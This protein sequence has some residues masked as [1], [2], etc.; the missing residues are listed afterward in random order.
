[1]TR[2]IAVIAEHL[3]GTLKPVTE[4]LISCARLLRQVL[5]APIRVVLLGDGVESMAWGLARGTGLNVTSLSAEGFQE[6]DTERSRS[7]L[8][9]YLVELDASHVLLAH[10]SM[11][12]DLAPGLALALGASC[13]T[14]VEGLETGD[15]GINF[16]R[17]L[18]GGKLMAYVRS[19]MPVTLLTVMQG[20]FARPARTSEGDVA[21]ASLPPA[22][23][24]VDER[25]VHLPPS[26]SRFLGLRQAVSQDAGLRDA[27]CIVSAGRGIGSIDKLELV[28]KLAEVFDNA[29]IASSRPLCDL[30][31][32]DY[33]RQVGLTGATVAPALYLACGISGSAQHLA[34]LRGAGSIVAVN[35]DPHAAIFNLADVCVVADLA[36]FIPE[37]IKAVERLRSKGSLESG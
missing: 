21:I 27:R 31:W 29:T 11:G 20:S 9:D 7:L 25:E 15:D 37:F 5:E 30:G 16:F 36:E 35:I 2:P 6:P 24:N 10:S 13:I 8:T 33:S 18:R 34:G 3:E 22:S 14:G 1:M 23:G 17:G 12:L 28:R 32:L 19:E 26:R 4:D